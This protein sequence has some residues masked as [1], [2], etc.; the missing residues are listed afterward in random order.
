MDEA[1]RFFLSL[2]FLTIAASAFASMVEPSESRIALQRVSDDAPVPQEPVSPFNFE[3][4]PADYLPRHGLEYG[5]IVEPN[6]DGSPSFQFRPYV[7]FH[8]DVSNTYL[9]TFYRIG[10]TY[11]HAVDHEG[12]TNV[13]TDSSGN[14]V[15]T[16]NYEAFGSV[17]RSN[18]TLNFTPSY[19]GKQYDQDTGLY[20]YNAR[21]Y[22]PELGRFLNSDAARDGVNWYE[23]VRDN[24][25]RF[26][27]PTGLIIG[28]V[29]DKQTMQSND[30]DPKNPVYMGTMGDTVR[31]K[32]C[33]ADAVTRVIN[34]IDPDA[35]LTTDDL[36]NGRGMFPR[37]FVDGQGNMSDKNIHDAIKYYTKQDYSV[38]NYQKQDTDL[39]GVI[40]AAQDSKETDYLIG[41]APLVDHNLQDHQVN[42]TGGE[43]DNGT[44]NVK[45]TSDND[46][47]NDAHP[48]RQFATN[49][50]NRKA[51]INQVDQVK[52]IVPSKNAQD[53]AKAVQAD[54]PKLAE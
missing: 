51:D 37:S 9:E 5:L 17:I 46:A 11:Y 28:D 31:T 2:F 35:H 52:A 45:G 29:D 54:Q 33:L 41:R 38:Q 34:K 16:G 44:L 27:D 30:P 21:F 7:L 24:P 48:Q 13:V 49:E 6:A 1:R 10:T 4:S 15:W 22:D 40:G 50:V 36:V 8:G 42:I 32:A 20:Y 3:F 53:F 12:T 39:D 43:K 25:L 26:D 19:T 23:Y 47:G 18:G 14:V